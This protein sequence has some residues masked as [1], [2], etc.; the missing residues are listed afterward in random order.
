MVVT[1]VFVGSIVKSV[2]AL[3]PSFIQMEPVWMSDENT[4]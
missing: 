3:K 2:N 4:K 1:N